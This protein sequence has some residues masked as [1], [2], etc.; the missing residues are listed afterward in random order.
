MN[1]ARLLWGCVWRAS[2]FGLGLGASLG[3]AY[4]AALMLYAYP[5]GSIGAGSSERHLGAAVGYFLIGMFWS[6]ILG[7]LFGGVFFGGPAGLALG[8]LHGLLLAGLTRALTNPPR[9]TRRCRDAAGR[10]C[11]A[12][13]VAALLCA[14]ALTG[15]DPSAFALIRNTDGVFGDGALDV[16]L[17]ILGPTAIA[18]WAGRWAG[19]EVASWYA[20]EA[21]RT[22][23]GEPARAAPPRAASS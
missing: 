3:G 23:S 9:D 6:A 10:A 14:W 8:V 11:A 18:G 1:T 17:I 22:D 19:R 20:R 15:F 2:F 16:A 5:I 21:G 12:A 13:S 4:G 7:A